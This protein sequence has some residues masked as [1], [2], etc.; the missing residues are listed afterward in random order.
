[1][2]PP[3]A[4]APTTRT[5]A[6]CH[7]R[8]FFVLLD[9]GFAN[10]RTKEARLVTLCTLLEPKQVMPKIAAWP[11][12]QL[13]RVTSRPATQK[14]RVDL[15]PYFATLR[16]WKRAHTGFRLRANAPEGQ[17]RLPIS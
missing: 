5:P 15:R 16:P 17:K 10:A 6:K 2:S 11:W 1:M 13:F 7:L 12:R 3:N 9:R 14:T 8:S 4:A